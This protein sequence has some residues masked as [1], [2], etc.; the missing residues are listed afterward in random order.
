MKYSPPASETTEDSRHQNATTAPHASA[1]CD[2]AMY[3]LRVRSMIDLPDWPASASGDP[4][5]V[6]CEEPPAPA[7]F[8]SARYNARSTFE[9]GKVEIEVGGVARYTAIEGSCI[10]VAPEPDALAEDILLYLT[11][12]MFGVVLHQRGILPLHASCVTID[13]AGVAFAGPS[14]SGKSTLVAALLHRGAAFVTDDICAMTPVRSGHSCVWP[15]AARVKLD[16]KGMAEFKGVPAELEPAGGNRGKYHVPVASA[17]SQPD[18]VPLCR[19]Y[20]PSFGEGPC[21]LERLGGLEA[22][23]ALVD[24]TYLQTYASALGVSSHVFRK[25]AELSQTLTVSR[26]IRPHGF[27]HLETALDLIE[28][29]VRGEE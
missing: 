15:G 7:R 9:P 25:V 2:V 5:V 29:D 10:K 21:R 18:P 1:A 12:A 20:L 23:S 19:V 26:L 6:I 3:G 14:G 13:G 4:Q 17:Q 11:G 16:H 8:Q 28:R 27:V 24:E 22:I